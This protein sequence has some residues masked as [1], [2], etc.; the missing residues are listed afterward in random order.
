LFALTGYG[1]EGAAKRAEDAGFDC[2]LTKPVDAALLRRLLASVSTDHE[3]SPAG[4]ASE[5][6]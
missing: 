6:S 1:D 4:R 3:Q 5:R 2:H